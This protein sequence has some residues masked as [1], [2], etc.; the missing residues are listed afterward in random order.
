[1]ACD[2]ESTRLAIVLPESQVQSSPQGD[3][4]MDLLSCRELSGIHKLVQVRLRV[5]QNH[6]AFETRRPG[7]SR[8]RPN[9][10]HQLHSRF[11]Q[12]R[13]LHRSGSLSAT[14]S[15][16]SAISASIA[17]AAATAQQDPQE[18]SLATEVQLDSWAPKPSGSWDILGVLSSGCPLSCTE[19][20]DK[21]RLTRFYS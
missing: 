7:F 21:I 3:L 11:Q 6:E 8:I 12:K 15:C 1:M 10:K 9:F 2:S 20:L 18:P 19:A 4:S 17:P 13:V 5:Q 14:L 16:P